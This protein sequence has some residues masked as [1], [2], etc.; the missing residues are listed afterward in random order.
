MT[1]P[2]IDFYNPEKINPKS[3][4]GTPDAFWDGMEIFMSVREYLKRNRDVLISRYP[5]EKSTREEFTEGREAWRQLNEIGAKWKAVFGMFLEDQS[6]KWEIHIGAPTAIDF[7]DDLTSEQIVRNILK[8]AQ[9]GWTPDETLV[10]RVKELA[11]DFVWLMGLCAHHIHRWGLEK[12][13]WNRPRIRKLKPARPR[14]ILTRSEAEKVKDCR[15]YLVS[16]REGIIPQIAAGLKAYDSKGRD[17]RVRRNSRK[18]H[19]A[20]SIQG[21]QKSPEEVSSLEPP[22]QGSADPLDFLR[23]IQSRLPHIVTEYRFANAAA[24]EIKGSFGQLRQ[25]LG[26]PEGWLADQFLGIEKFKQA[27]DVSEQF[28]DQAME[29]TDHLW[30]RL[31]NWH[32]NNGSFISAS[33]SV[34]LGEKRS[35]PYDTA[36]GHNRELSEGESAEWDQ[37]DDPISKGEWMVVMERHLSKASAILVTCT[38]AASQL[39]QLLETQSSPEVKYAIDLTGSVKWSRQQLDVAQ[40]WLAEIKKYLMVQ[41]GQSSSMPERRRGRSAN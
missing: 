29:I 24:D 10:H 8:K 21:S 13:I 27:L 17:D 20:L 26:E 31:T 38:R 19:P 33:V 4:D 2:K 1:T 9:T 40:Q 15:K 39:E 34:Y 37:G 18:T 23:I 35:E 7:T 12:G 30:Q 16:E 41:K 22:G 32:D 36:L 6:N 11:Q 25:G 28:K 3:F 5:T 14:R